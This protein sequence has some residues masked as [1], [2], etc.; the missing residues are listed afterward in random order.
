MPV[1][2]TATVYI[3][4]KDADSVIESGMPASQTEGVKFVKMEDG[5]AMFAVESGKYAFQAVIGASE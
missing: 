4:A 1:G 2:T 3:P 5:S